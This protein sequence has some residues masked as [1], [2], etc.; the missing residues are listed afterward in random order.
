MDCHFSLR[1]FGVH[2]FFRAWPVISGISFSELYPLKGRIAGC[3]IMS[4]CN[5]RLDARGRACYSLKRMKIHGLLCG[6]RS[7][8]NISEEPCARGAGHVFLINDLRGYAMAKVYL[9]IARARK[10]KYDDSMPGKLERY[11]EGKS[12]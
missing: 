5:Y 10:W 7:R 3:D 4:P 8:N 1:T 11:A 12:D 9:P 2:C 6:C